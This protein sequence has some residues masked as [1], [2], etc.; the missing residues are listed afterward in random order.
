MR[1]TW[2]RTQA[3]PHVYTRPILF[4]CGSVCAFVH[5]KIDDGCFVRLSFAN[6][7]PSLACGAAISWFWMSKGACSSQTEDLCMVHVPYDWRA[8][9]RNFRRPCDSSIDTN[10]GCIAKEEHIYCIIL[11]HSSP[12]QNKLLFAMSS[13]GH[14]VHTHTHTGTRTALG[15]PH[16]KFPARCC[17]RRPRVVSRGGLLKPADR[18]AHHNA[19]QNCGEIV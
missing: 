6:A 16:E 17:C 14:R 12:Q 2:F 1:S 5:S 18:G 15:L 8:K 3:K 7:P 9:S 19:V 13:S 10:S 11:R 4:M